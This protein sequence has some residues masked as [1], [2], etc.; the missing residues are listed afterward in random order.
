MA[1]TVTK[2]GSVINILFDGATAWDS[3]TLYASGLVVESIEFKPTAI[4]DVMAVREG[5]ASGPF[6]F[7]EKAASAY[8]NKIKYFN[9]EKSEK[10]FYPYVKGDEASAGTLLI[11]QLK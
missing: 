1:N 4:N 8:D 10:R 9:T 6:L 3:T 7:H 2:S 5:S 11:I